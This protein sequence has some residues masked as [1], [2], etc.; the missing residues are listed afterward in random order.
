MTDEHIDIASPL[1]GEPEWQAM[2]ESLESGWITQGPKV[3]EF[4]RLVSQRHH[5]AHAIAVTSCTTGLHLALVALGIG[6]GDE[7]IVPA[8]TWVATAN[9]AVYCGATPVFVDVE[10]D[11]YNIDPEGVRAAVTP[12]T[13]AVIAVHLFGLCADMDA[14]ADA[15]PDHVAIVED[16]ACAI[17]ADYRGRPAGGLGRAAAF[18]FH[19]RKIV[20]TG[21]GGMVTTADAELAARLACLRNHGAS[22]SEEDRHSS[23]QPWMLPDFEVLGFNYR[24]T[25]LQASVGIVQ[26]AKLDDMLAE[27]RRRADWYSKRLVGI[28]WLRTPAVP[29]HATHSWQSYVTVV[30]SDAPAPRNE[31][32]E[33]LNQQGIQ[34]RP[35]THAVPDLGW[36]RANFRTSL[37]DYPVAGSLR[38]ASMA[39]PLHNRMTD[40]DYERVADALEAI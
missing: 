36:Y 19:P 15:V 17:G 9:A 40:R 13:R 3:A 30:G 31:I 12:R 7:V 32:M 39:I 8:F 23:P 34:T 29:E 11:S 35:G 27:R 18:S 2:R 6:P 1:T 25:D 14:I 21:E 5:V 26:M 4:E 37:A 24:M 20:T 28:G 33:R 10:P 22:V 38:D 16:A